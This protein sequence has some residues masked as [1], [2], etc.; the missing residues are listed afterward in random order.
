MEN[1]CK[2]DVLQ[3]LNEFDVKSDIP[4]PSLLEEY[5]HFVASTGDTVFP[6]TII[7]VL[8][9]RK[10]EQVLCDFLITSSPDSV[11]TSPNVDSFKYALMKEK[12]LEALEYFNQAPFTI[13]RLCEVMVDP[14]RY[15]KRIDKLM[16]AIEKNLLVT[17]TTEPRRPSSPSPHL[18]GVVNG[19]EDRTNGH[20]SE[21]QDEEQMDT[22]GPPAPCQPVVV[23]N[24]DECS[25]AVR[26]TEEDEE[27]I[28]DIEVDQAPDAI[29]SHTPTQNF[30][31]AMAEVQQGGSSQE[32]LLQIQLQM[33]EQ[34]QQ[35]EQQILVGAGEQAAAEDTSSSQSSEK[36]ESEE[37]D[38]S[39][40]SAEDSC[41]N[42]ATSDL[43]HGD[44]RESPLEPDA[45][46]QVRAH[47]GLGVHLAEAFLS[48]SR[49]WRPGTGIEWILSLVSDH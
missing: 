27:G 22:S 42:D 23:G 45:E 3:A 6:W 46:Q 38:A 36:S 10:I 47:I 49:N 32:N 1:V 33:R 29:P 35:R 21:E 37:T 5:L 14:K 2:E 13:Q 15:Y 4:I 39:T 9:R 44:A 31:I 20:H 48:Q 17:T 18:S 19:F 25:M 8:M 24:F 12:I 11:P 26:A 16:R 7:K 41:S 43:E 40:R 34:Q 30:D 28:E